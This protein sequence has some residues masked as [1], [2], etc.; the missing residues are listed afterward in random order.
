MTKH[1]QGRAHLL[2][3]VGRQENNNRSPRKLTQWSP[4]TP[5]SALHQAQLEGRKTEITPP[6]RLKYPEEEGND[7]R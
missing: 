6:I 2:R 4:T 1:R 3:S 5:W 7:N